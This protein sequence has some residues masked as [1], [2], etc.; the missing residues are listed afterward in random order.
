MKTLAD[1]VQEY[2]AYHQNA[3]NKL[4]HFVGVP[5]VTYSIL[6]FFGWFRFAYA[7]DWP[8]S[9]ATLFYVTVVLY[10]LRLDWQITLFQ[11]PFTLSLLFLSDW[12]ARWPWQPSLLVFLGAFVMG[13]IIQLTGHAIEGRR[14]A[15]ADNIMQ[16]FNAPVF[17][18]TEA[19]VLLGFRS[20]LQQAMAA[21]PESATLHDVDARAA[22]KA[23][24]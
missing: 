21:I 10:F 1:H 18:T 4:T 6:H 12:I 2:G 15:L 20:D 22:E 13:W 9:F 8:I 17:L 23:V 5:L 24:A 14:P 7:P 11:A 16:L 3:W 19:V